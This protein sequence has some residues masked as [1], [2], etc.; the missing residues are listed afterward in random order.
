MQ[1]SNI[2]NLLIKASR[3]FLH[4]ESQSKVFKIAEILQLEK[5]INNK[6]NKLVLNWICLSGSCIMLRNAGFDSNRKRVAEKVVF[7]IDMKNP[8]VCNGC[9][10]LLLHVAGNVC[11][12]VTNMCYL[13]SIQ[14][15]AYS[16]PGLTIERQHKNLCC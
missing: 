16:C 7:M 10:S 5:I 6:D 13:F 11:R 4:L 2:F 14:H 1:F 8:K 12:C 3:Q 9:F 15:L